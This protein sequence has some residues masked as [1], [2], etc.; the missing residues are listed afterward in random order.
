MIK[1]KTKTHKPKIISNQNTKKT[2]QQTPQKA[3]PT[4]Q[5]KQTKK[6]HKTNSCWGNG[7][8]EWDLHLKVKTVVYKVVEQ[9]TL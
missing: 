3:Q 2:P 8:S 5:E 1:K 9:A 4:K 7:E 6:T